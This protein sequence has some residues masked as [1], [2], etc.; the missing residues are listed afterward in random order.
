MR[1][2]QR[3]LAA[4]RKVGKVPLVAGMN[5][6][7]APAAAGARRVARI[8]PDPERHQVPL[9]STM[10]TTAAPNCG[11]RVNGLCSPR[12]IPRPGCDTPASTHH[13]IIARAELRDRQP[14]RAGNHKIADSWLAHLTCTRQSAAPALAAGR[15]PAM[16]VVWVCVAAL[17][18]LLAIRLGG[19]GTAGGGRRARVTRSAKL[20]RRRGRP[21]NQRGAGR[22][23]RVWS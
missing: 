9:S 4:E 3:L 19:D 10:S 12:R 1:D 17:C 22:A 8:R 21:H 20:G 2:H 16:T 18:V 5:P 13:V 11:K 23:V 7:R 6:R 15:V 14:L